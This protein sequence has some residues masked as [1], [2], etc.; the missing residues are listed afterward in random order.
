MKSL[1]E[2]ETAADKMNLTKLKRALKDLSAVFETCI[3]L[4]NQN[5]EAGCKNDD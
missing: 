4:L 5:G 1:K 2:K 3:L